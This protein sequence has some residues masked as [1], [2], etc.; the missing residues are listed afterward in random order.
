MAGNERLAWAG[1]A[2]VTTL[3][4]DVTATGLSISIA[5]AT[6][7]PTGARFYVVINPGGASEEKALVTRSGT[8]LTCASTSERGVDGTSA[9]AHSSGER[10]YPI[11]PAK[12]MDE[13]NALASTLTTKGDVLAHTGS[14]HTRV[15]VGTNGQVLI[16]DSAQASGLKW[17]QLDSSGIA[18]NAV[19][20]NQIASNAVTSAELADDSVTPAKMEPG[21]V[22]LR[23]AANQSTGAG[24]VSISW[25][26]EDA[27]PDGYITVTSTTLTVPT[28]KG[29]LH[30]IDANSVTSAGT[31]SG[32]YLRVVRN[33]TDVFMGTDGQQAN[34]SLSTLV[35]LAQGDTLTIDYY[36]AS[37][38]TLTANVTIVRVA[39]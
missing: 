27:D 16:A 38:V 25:D 19:G 14:A 10:I 5:S 15:G 11:V 26:T 18:D 21:E 8:T 17:G 32:Q 6:G 28:G 33:G 24:W 39:D 35:R 23:R 12:V 2:T 30:T 13:V 20:T 4:A 1:G 3:T 9:F 22:R 37:G 31:A 36:S 7:W 34:R 29:G